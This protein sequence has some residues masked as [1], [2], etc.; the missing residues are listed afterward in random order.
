M[1]AQE[2]GSL[3]GCNS[4]SNGVL[5]PTASANIIAPGAVTAGVI[6]GTSGAQITPGT[7]TGFTLTPAAISA[8]ST[9][10]TWG[11]N[12]EMCN[13]SRGIKGAFGCP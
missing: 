8:T 5:T 2:T 3:T 11:L 12:T 10:M 7:N 13:P 9:S 6:T 1:C 4:G